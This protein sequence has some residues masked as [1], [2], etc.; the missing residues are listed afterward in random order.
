[1]SPLAPKRQELKIDTT[2]KSVN[3]TTPTPINDTPAVIP[4]AGEDWNKDEPRSWTSQ[5]VTMWMYNSGVEAAIVEKFEFHDITGTVL[6]DLQFQDLKEL[7]IQSFGKRHQVWNQICTLRGGDGRVSPVPTP[8]QDT[9]RPASNLTRTQ[10]HSRSK[11]QESPSDECVTPITPG[12]GK[13]R[14]RK[15][16]RNG[17]EPITPAESVSIVAIEQMIPKPHKCPKGENCSKWKKQQK[18]LR[19]LHDE[20]GFPI[21]PEEGGR[22]FI[23]GDPGNPATAM[24]N[25]QLVHRSLHLRTC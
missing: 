18:L 3:E 24:N 25:L 7:G 4:C 6:L 23:T 13:R 10:S 20:H 2:F 9:D 17:D 8:F 12:A 5:Q 22:V 21:S 1:M 15:H 16:R 19:R 11:S 14:R